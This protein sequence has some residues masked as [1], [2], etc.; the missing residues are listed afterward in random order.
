[1]LEIKNE[2]KQLTN[3]NQASQLGEKGILK[4][5]STKTEV[6]IVLCIIILLYLLLFKLI[7]E[8]IE[9]PKFYESNKNIVQ[10]NVSIDYTSEFLIVFN[11]NN[12]DWNDVLIVLNGKYASYCRTIESGKNHVFVFFQFTDPFTGQK[13]NPFTMRL[14]KI[15]I[16]C[17]TT[18]GPRRYSLNF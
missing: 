9:S 3:K 16:E 14:S 6:I 12:F 10:L 5:K 15:T 11:K 7:K 4:R 18:H 1:M 13:F 2:E 8:E 17:E